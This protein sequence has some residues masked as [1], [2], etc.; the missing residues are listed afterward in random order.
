VD[1]ERRF[2]ARE[3]LP[4]EYGEH[5]V[6]DFDDQTTKCVVNDRCMEREAAASR[7]PNILMHA[8]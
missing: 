8:D 4:F 5:A 2:I 3:V 7:A 6:L 1:W